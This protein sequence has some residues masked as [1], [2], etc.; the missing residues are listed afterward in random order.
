MYEW[1]RKNY[2][3]KNKSKQQSISSLNSIGIKSE[4]MLKKAKWEDTT[5]NNLLNQVNMNNNIGLN[6]NLHT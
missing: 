1:F 4:E 2:D 3:K 6:N 5:N